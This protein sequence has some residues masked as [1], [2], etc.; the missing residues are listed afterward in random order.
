MA[1]SKA[2]LMSFYRGI[3]GLKSDSPAATMR[4]AQPPTK[5]KDD[6]F[7]RHRIGWQA[8]DTRAIARSKPEG[9]FHP[10]DFNPWRLVFLQD[11][12]ARAI[13]TPEHAL[14]KAF[15]TGP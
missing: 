15:I 3:F 5:T 13:V 4:L 12:D 10:V 2:E 9:L 14:R 7:L 11:Y 1:T 6:F 8:R